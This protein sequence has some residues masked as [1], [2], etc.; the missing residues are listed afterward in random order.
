VSAP[1]ELRKLRLLCFI[2]AVA[3]AIGVWADLALQYTANPAHVGSAGYAYLLDVSRPRL[4]FGHFAGVIAV[5]AEIAG[6][7][8][9]ALGI[10]R[11]ATRI[12]FL[13]VAATAFAI[14]AAF[15]AM[16]ASIGLAL[17]FAAASGATPAFMAGLASAVWPAHHGLGA[18]TLVGIV[19]LSVIFSASVALGRTVFPRG[20]A[21]C[22]PLAVALILAGI[23]HFA[24]ALRLVALPAGLNFANLVLFL[25]AALTARGQTPQR[26]AA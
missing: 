7:W 25:T 10:A 24:P 5:L 9:V 18:I 1:T 3:A 22:S 11:P 15:H 26:A 19:L 6:F 8:G 13:A 12:A 4:L 16:F 17:Q 14:G 23:V 21:L 2:G 20:A